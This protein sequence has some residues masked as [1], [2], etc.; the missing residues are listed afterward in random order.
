MPDK[1]TTNGRVQLWSCGGGRQS[2]GI[3][4]LIIQGRLPRPDHV[5]MAAL[6]WERRETF[7]YVNAYI[8]PAMRNLGIQ[9]TYVS[10]KKYA[11]KGLWGGEDSKSLL[12]PA[13][14]N[15]SG[16]PSKMSEFCSGKWK[17]EVILRW[18]NEQP[19]WKERGVDCWIG[20]SWDEKRRRRASSRKWFQVAYPLL[21]MLPKCVPVN[22]CLDAVS[23]VGWPE[24][25]RS[26]CRHCPNQSDKEWTELT[27][28]EFS[29]ACRMEEDFRKVDPHAYLHRSLMPL[30]MVSLRPEVDEPGLFGGCSAGMCF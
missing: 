8:R 15:Q 6:E 30:Q 29:A 1:K 28:E 26:R 10:R 3:A 22:A 25:P 11:T 21:D 24:P 9:F 5:V 12:I 13:W 7:K 2:A 14:T 4:A 20:I 23:E 18:A 16:M 19:G 17:T 27:P